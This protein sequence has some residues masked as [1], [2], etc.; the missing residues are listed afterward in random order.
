MQTYEHFRYQ[1]GKSQQAF[2]TF[3]MRGGVANVLKFAGY[4]N[5]VNGIEFQLNGLQPRLTIYS[6]TTNGDQ[7]VNQADWNLDTMDGEG[8]SGITLDFEKEQILVIDFQAL[9]V[10][11]VRVGWDVCGQVVY[12]H[13]FEHANNTT[14]PYIAS[15]NLP[16][17]AGMTCT[18]TVSTTML[19]NCCSVISEGGQE[20]TSGYSFAVEGTGTAGNNTRAHILSVRP[21]TTFNSIANR[22]K[23]FLD[24]V[25]ILV[26]G[27][28]TVEW[29]LCV[30]QAIS[31]TTTFADVNTTYSAFEFNTAGTISGS[32]A[33][34][35]AAGYTPAT[36]TN[37]TTTSAQI[38]NRYPI[39]LDMAGVVRSLG[40]LS[41]I[42]T[43]LGATSAMRAIF[44][45]HEVR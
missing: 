40:T 27:N 29:E 1:P 41:L 22:S 12:C 20:T 34:V 8:G 26:T 19:F 16:I 36:A 32:P 9:Y 15:A 18:G 30:G 45:Y 25:E 10:G 14:H 6:T 31:G 33:I 44:N 7:H 39:T 11:R 43:G 28:T 2:I 37:K 38:A 13:E 21:K 24:S 42:A 17:R 5:G 3:N 4:S 23:F 35:I